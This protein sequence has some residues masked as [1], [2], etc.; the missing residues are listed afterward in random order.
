MNIV[1]TKIPDLLILEAAVFGDQ[2]GFFMETF[3]QSWFDNNSIKA[4]FVQDN[5]SASTKGVLRGLHYQQTKQQGKLVRV[6]VGE[7][8][9]VAVDIRPDSATYGQWF[10]T[11]LSAANKRQL[12]IPPGFA[13]GFQVVSEY[14]ECQYK[15][16]DYYDPNDQ[17]EIL[18]S[19]PSLNIQWPDT[20]PILSEKDAVAPLL[21]NIAP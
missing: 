3:R 4:H 12:Y 2:R 10:G 18:W 21:A 19:D 7:I 6:V 9:D 8:F 16:T 17:K 13:H 15:C 14:A 11:L 20:D 5:H 1:K